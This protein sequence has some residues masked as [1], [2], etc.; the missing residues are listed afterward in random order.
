MICVFFVTVEGC[1][2]EPSIKTGNQKN[3]SLNQ[4]GNIKKL[5]DRLE[6]Q[7]IK[8][9][10]L[11][12]GFPSVSYGND[13]FYEDRQYW[14][15]HKLEL[16]YYNVSVFNLKDAYDSIYFPNDSELHLKLVIQGCQC[17]YGATFRSLF[18]CIP[19]SLTGMDSVYEAK[20][21][22]LRDHLI[23][24]KYAHFRLDVVKSK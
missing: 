5:T 13:A 19:Q 9:V 11:E 24:T 16:E 22:A 17:R 15:D 6:K 23:L 7:Y 4:A 20:K 18:N 14:E 21:Y 1:S 8:I 10:E 12:N 2:V 3:A